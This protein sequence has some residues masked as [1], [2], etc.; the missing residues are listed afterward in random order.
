MLP[1]ASIHPSTY[2]NAHVPTSHAHRSSSKSFQLPAKT[3]TI[4]SK[5]AQ[6]AP[7][8]HRNPHTALLKLAETIGNERVFAKIA[9][10]RVPPRVGMAALTAPTNNRKALAKPPHSATKSHKSYTIP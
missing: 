10:F 7:I 1:R 3:T 2:P 8:H 4:A 5:T 9:T 6:S